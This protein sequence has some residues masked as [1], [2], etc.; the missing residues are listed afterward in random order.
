MPATEPASGGRDRGGVGLG[1]WREVCSA[2]GRSWALTELVWR[3]SCGGL[4]DL[5][6]P[7]VD[8][9]PAGPGPAAASPLVRYRD[10]LPAG[11]AAVDLG[12]AVTPVG[13]LRPG[14]WVKADYE[15]PTGSFKD[16]G[17][18]VMVGLAAALGVARLVV[19]SSGNAG[20]AAAAHAARA[21]LAA[22]V[23]LPAGTD[24]AKVAGI[25]GYGA[26]VVEVPGG[27]AAAAEAAVAAVGGPAGPAM[28]GAVAGGAVTGGAVAPW[29]ASHV[30]QPAFHHGVKTLAFE[31]Y[32]QIP[33][34]ADGTV[35][36]PAGNG[37]LVLGLWLGFGELVALGRMGRR[38][39]L[40]AAQAERCA[41]LAGAPP[42]PG[43][44]ATA[45]AGIAIA[46]PPRHR[47]IRGA[48]MATGGR[49]AVVAEDAILAAQSELNGLGHPVEPTGAVA[50]AA[51]GAVGAR[52]GRPGSGAGG[53]P[54]VAVLT[55]R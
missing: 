41:P 37:T 46:D 10:A 39:V 11:A 35:V 32:E 30:W 26:E 47:Q 31:L 23:Y 22:T 27:R 52:G 13:E 33:G 43:A 9:L 20:K 2:C 18:A 54:L 5:V 3:C 21:G 44:E 19:D 15:H 25:A 6:G 42:A 49:V 1:R 51:L 14:W 12:M 29:Y 40:V 8:P 36:V 34:I 45:A 53:G 28:G 4:L 24:P 7:V 17:A 55:G 16:R 48:V 50:W 38:P